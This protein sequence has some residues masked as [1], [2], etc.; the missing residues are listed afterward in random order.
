MGSDYDMVSYPA[1]KPK[2]A[3]KKGS[4]KS[5]KTK[6]APLNI[7]NIDFGNIAIESV[8]TRQKEKKK[9]QK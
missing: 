9:I 6:K 5:K 3:P 7:D 2:Q 1:A 4:S 8:D